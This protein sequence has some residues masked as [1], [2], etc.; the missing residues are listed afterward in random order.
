MD[1]LLGPGQKKVDEASVNAECESPP[2][3]ARNTF[4]LP[5]RSCATHLL[6][7]QLSAPSSPQILKHGANPQVDW[8]VLSKHWPLKG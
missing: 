3:Q 6:Q 5:T 2:L 1:D 7:L 8:E 4:C